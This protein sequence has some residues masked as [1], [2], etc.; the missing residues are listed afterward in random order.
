MMMKRKM[1]KPA[2]VFY[3]HVVI[4]KLCSI[5]EHPSKDMLLANRTF[6]LYALFISRLPHNGSAKVNK[7]DKNQ[8]LER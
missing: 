8:T 2:K 1:T 6:R 4:C 7:Y 3:F 5:H